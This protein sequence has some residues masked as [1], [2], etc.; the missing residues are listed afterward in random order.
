MGQA[1]STIKAYTWD[2]MFPPV[3]PLKKFAS[4]EEI[5]AH[6]NAGE[7][8]EQRQW[9]EF[10]TAHKG[11]LDTI[12]ER[13]YEVVTTCENMYCSMSYPL[14][15]KGHRHDIKKYLETRLREYFG[16]IKF[17]VTFEDKHVKM[18]MLED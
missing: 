9:R 1:A 8:M 17:N 11:Q 3:K 15:T 7:S 14:D 13:Y 4:K 12:F 18:V 5:V 10:F 2:T 16:D 6:R